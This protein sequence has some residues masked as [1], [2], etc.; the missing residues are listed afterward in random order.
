MARARRRLRGERV[1]TGDRVGV[2]KRR[3]ARLSRRGDSR[4]ALVALRQMVAL[5]GQARHWVQLGD[6]LRRARK[7][8]E[9][10]HA[11]KQGLFLHEREGNPARAATVARLILAVDPCCSAASK[12]LDRAARN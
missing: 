7:H 5:G 8:P 10:L 3:A 1:T 4:K 11:L 2:L 6:A 9:A 12:C